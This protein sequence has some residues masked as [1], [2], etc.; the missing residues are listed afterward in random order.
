MG[1]SAR[2][3]GS[4]A[5]R[6]ARQEDGRRK[7]PPSISILQ[8]DADRGENQPDRAG[9]EPMADLAIRIAGDVVLLAGVQRQCGAG[10]DEEDA[11]GEQNSQQA[12]IHGVSV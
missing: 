10:R 8:P 7:V 1:R 12:G 9:Y 5:T 11:D 3:G 6:A 4:R 2:R